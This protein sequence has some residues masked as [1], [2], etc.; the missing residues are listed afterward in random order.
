[1]DIATSSFGSLARYYRKQAGLDQRAAADAIEV[2]YTYISKIEGNKF[3]PPSN[4]VIEKMAKLYDVDP[5]MFYRVAKRLPPRWEKVLFSKNA[6]YGVEQ[7]LNEL[8]ETH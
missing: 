5:L 3:G 4:D 1:M 7:L 8:E 6:F 2:H